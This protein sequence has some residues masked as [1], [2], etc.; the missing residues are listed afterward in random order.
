MKKIILQMTLL[1]LFTNIYALE[2]GIGGDFHI[3]DETYVGDDSQAIYN[4][5]IL[6]PFLRVEL[7]ESS[8][9]E[10]F[11][12]YKTSTELDLDSTNDDIADDFNYSYIGGGFNYGRIAY[13]NNLVALNYSLESFFT[14]G[15]EP[16]GADAFEYD[17]FL[18]NGLNLYANVSAD[19]RITENLKLRFSHKVVRFTAYYS[20]WTPN[21]TDYKLVDYLFD[22]KYTGFTPNFSFYYMM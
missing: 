4:E 9:I 16:S 14:Y 12:Y 2:M 19:F 10:P 1:L 17:D 15:L 5:I 6:K 3:S 21:S 18:S 11:I 22:T 7:S 8:Y 20:D 13:K